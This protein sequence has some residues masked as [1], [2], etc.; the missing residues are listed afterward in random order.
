MT[1]KLRSGRTLKQALEDGI[2][3]LDGFYTF[4]VGTADG[5]AVVRDPSPASTR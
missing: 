5:F 3:D 2:K 1:W 4:L